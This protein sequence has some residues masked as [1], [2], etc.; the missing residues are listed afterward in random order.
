MIRPER[1]RALLEKLNRPVPRPVE[2]T[3]EITTTILFLLVVLVFTG[4]HARVPGLG[5]ALDRLGDPLR[6][7][8]PALLVS[9]LVMLMLRD[10]RKPR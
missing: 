1:L 5:P 7:L 3:V 8:V 2:L 6:S 9:T 10:R 4:L